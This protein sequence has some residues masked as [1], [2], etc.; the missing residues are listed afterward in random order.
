MN[1]FFQI[2]FLTTITFVHSQITGTVKDTS[3]QPLPYVNIFIENTYSGT[4][5]NEEGYYELSVSKTGTYTVV[6]QFLGYKTLT[7]KIEAAK[8]PYTA[9]VTLQDENINLSE[10]VI[11][12]NENPA[13]RIIRAA[14]AKRQLYLE[15]LNSYTADFYSKGIIRIK[16][17]PEQFM[18]QDV[19]DFDGALDS[20]RTGILYLSET[21]SKIKYIKPDLIETVTASKISGDSNG[22]S[23]NSAMDVNFN[24]YN[25]TVSINNDIISPI[26][27]YAF[28]YYR[29]KLEG[30]FY[31]DEGHLIHKINI[32]PK[33][34]N[35]RVFSGSIYVVEDTWALYGIDIEVKGSQI[36]IPP[37]DTIRIRQNLTF[38]N[39]EDQWLVR[40]Q[41]IDFNYSFLGFKGDG[42]FVANYTNYN[43][44]AEIHPQKNKN[45]ILVFEKE[46][47]KKEGE[48]WNT[49]RPVPLTSEESKDYVRRDS[50]ETLRASKVYLDSVDRK[51]NK[52]K[53]LNLLTGYTFEDSYN[54]KSFSIS[55]PLEEIHFNTVQGY[56]VSLDA[57]FTKKYND[58]KKFISVKGGINYSFETQRLRGTLGGQYRFNAINN[59]TV[60]GGFGV[61]TQQFHRSNPISNSHNDISSLFFESNYIKIYDNRFAKI[62]YSMEV[63]NG[64]KFSTQLA[65]ENRKALF[66]STNY[67]FFPIDDLNYTSNNPLAPDTLGTAPFLNHNLLRFNFDIAIRFGEKYMS[68]PDFKF[69]VS[70]SNYPQLYFNYTKGFNSSLSAY[71]FDHLSA[72]LKQNINLKTTGILNYNFIGGTFFG[73]KNLAFTDYKHFNGNLTH[74]NTKGNYMSNFKNMGYYEFSTSK[75]YFEYHVEHDFKGYILGKIPYMNQLNF[76]LIAGV[77]GLSIS[78][79]NP[80][81]EF[82]IGLGNI[83][84]KK[85]RFLRVDYVRSYVNGVADEAL[86]FGLSF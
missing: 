35:D 80:Y 71:N 5:S 23:F 47:N 26:A 50:I 9:N 39:A 34:E 30:E 7:K 66:N 13:N 44:N 55:G 3:G 29:Y 42:S 51:N 86:M 24:L 8:F 74:V 75:D 49:K 60:W 84:W 22:M 16:D 70:N 57:N 73:N 25:N 36:Q 38:D 64:L 67:T 82:N 15:K 31:D 40:A 41:T 20:T 85:Y 19:G 65:Y 14:I 32:I 59:A 68:Y 4:T 79:Q 6:F 76:N 53:I 1:K 37:A 46:A 61:K 17:A 33:R 52:F 56:N 69:N 12:A 77:H 63:F 21:M 48:F 18:G 43:L 81:Q 11:D 58:F 10:V 72:R 27:D 62:G 2:L 54:K 78:K 28:N 45:E 83:G